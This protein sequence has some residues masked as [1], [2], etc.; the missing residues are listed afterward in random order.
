M[1]L[2]FRIQPLYIV[3]C[4]YLIVSDEVSLALDGDRDVQMHLSCEY[5]CSGTHVYNIHACFLQFTRTCII[6]IKLYIM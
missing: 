5:Q 3:V 4:S 1:Q 6:Q 2:P